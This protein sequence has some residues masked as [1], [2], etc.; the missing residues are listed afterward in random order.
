MAEY[1]IQEESLTGIGGGIR[2]LTGKTAKLSPSGMK[3]ELSTLNTYV[4]NA[5]NAVKN[6]GVTVSSTKKLKD[7]ATLINSIETGVPEGVG[8]LFGYT[9]ASGT[10]TPTVDT[11]EPIIV[12]TDIK[13]GKTSIKG[14]VMF[15]FRDSEVTSQGTQGNLGHLFA[16]MLQNATSASTSTSIKDYALSAYHSSSGV[17]QHVITPSDIATISVNSSGCVQILLNAQSGKCGFLKGCRYRWIYIR[18]G[19]GE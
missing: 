3:T 2:T 14:D 13:P 7:L 9:I 4:T 5:L 10:I 8:E 17:K 18:R 15:Y 1:L 16:I 19:L 6:K 12:T 11:F